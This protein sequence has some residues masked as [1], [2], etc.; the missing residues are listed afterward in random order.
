MMNSISKNNT[1]LL[2]ETLMIA[3]ESAAELLGVKVPGKLGYEESEQGNARRALLSVEEQAQQQKIQDAKTQQAYLDE[4][5]QELFSELSNQISL[6]L[7]KPGEIFYRTLGLEEATAELLDA[8]AS[9]SFSLA[10][11]ENYIEAFPWLHDD[12]IALVNS[13]YFRRVDARGRLIKVDTLRT[14]L[15]FLGLDNFQLFFI[16]MLLRKALPPI[17]EP[18]T[19]TNSRTWHYIA[20][21]GALTLAL[22]EQHPEVNRYRL[23][24]LNMLGE[25]GRLTVTRLYFKM[26]SDLLQAELDLASKRGDS[27]RHNGLILLKPSAHH[28]AQLQIEFADKIAASLVDYMGFKRLPILSSL[29]TIASDE[30]LDDDLPAR[31]T[32]QARAFARYRVLNTEKFIDKQG[33]VALFHGLKMSPETFERLKSVNGSDLPVAT[34]LR[35]L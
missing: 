4:L 29:L 18:F 19:R 2:F 25:M 1:E 33:I 28:I 35:K 31:L 9:P 12:L 6:Q 3:K 10:R 26:F 24:A 30:E 21:N 22:A 14:A 34:V 8:L 27:R 32:L 17:T 16:P 13:R 20:L 5:H 7:Q 23:F 11:L 15:N